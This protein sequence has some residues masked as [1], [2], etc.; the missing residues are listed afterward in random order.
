MTTKRKTHLIVGDILIR[1][2]IQKGQ[3]CEIKAITQTDL[4]AKTR[5]YIFDGFSV[6]WPCMEQMFVTDGDG[7]FT[8]INENE[9]K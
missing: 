8:V 2:E 5:V 4:Q 7:N 1:S 9:E 3:H 6:G